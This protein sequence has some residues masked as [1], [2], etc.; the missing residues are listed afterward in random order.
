MP[1]WPIGEQ[2]AD[3]RW[4]APSA[5]RNK[6]PIADVLARVLPSSGLVLEIGSGTGQHVAH[7]AKT[8]PE[9]AWQPSDADTT[10]RESVSRWIEAENLS[11][12]RAPLQLDVHDRPWAIAAADAIV[13]INV[14]HVSPWSAAIALFK[15]ARDI[16]GSHGAVVLY[17]P[18]RRGGHHTA[19][20]NERF[21]ASLRAHDPRWGV[22]DLD[23]V[24]AVAER[25]GFVRA[26]IVEMPANNLCVVFRR[27][28]PHR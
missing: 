24:T 6:G 8:F 2:L 22:R 28:G 25:A 5:E 9:L 26:D 27:E 15:G 4:L 13:C 21:D 3:G 17:G 20:S 7:F 1:A 11:N 12:V 14:L 23:D 18:Y 10:Y 16:V 19:P